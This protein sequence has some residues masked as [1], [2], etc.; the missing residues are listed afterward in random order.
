MNYAPVHQRI[1]ELHLWQKKYFRQWA[2][3]ISNSFHLLFGRRASF[4]A[5]VSRQQYFAID[6]S[7][8]ATIGHGGCRFAPKA[9]ICDSTSNIGFAP[10]KADIISFDHFVGGRKEVG[11]NIQSERFCDL[12]IDHELKFIR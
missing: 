1:S 8:Q 11:R 12:E 9:D 2:K 10:K 6:K 5:S 3:G 7:I 4:L